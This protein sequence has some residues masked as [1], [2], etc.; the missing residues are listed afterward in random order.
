M[1]VQVGDVNLGAGNN[2]NQRLN[3]NPI[4][5]LRTRLL[6]DNVYTDI[7]SELNLECKYTSE[8]DLAN[9]LNYITY[10]YLSALSLNCN[11][12]SKKSDEIKNLLSNLNSKNNSDLH[13]LCLQETRSNDSLRFNFNG[14]NCFLNGRD[15]S[16]GGV[17]I[18]IKD[19]IS[20]EK[21]SNKF[22][23]KNI[24]KQSA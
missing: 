23:V 8:I 15:T 21:L 6:Y 2:D 7:L 16:S 17:G 20:C 14:Y 3:E 22:F 19:N 12:L 9:Y 11:S 5:N 10:P 13:I 1:V 24:L 18:L 4:F